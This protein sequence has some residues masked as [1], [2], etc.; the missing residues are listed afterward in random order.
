MLIRQ[1]NV[2]DLDQLVPLFDGYRQFYGRAADL[3]AARAFLH[4]RF[5]NSQSTIFLAMDDSGRALGF[6]QLYPSFSSV[7]L[8][9]TLILNDLFVSPDARRAG[10]AAALLE[11]A[12][13][14]GRSI[15]AIRL[16]LTTGIANDT[17]K[18]LY[19]SQGW[20]QDEAFHVFHLGL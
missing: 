6:T 17:A 16:T 9:K 11:A 12:A 8:A 5:K 10:V 1:A 20:Q 14:Y 13:R 2:E 3:N 7:S 19:V 15:E 18:A 4:E